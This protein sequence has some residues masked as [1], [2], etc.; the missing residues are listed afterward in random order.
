MCV[1]GTFQTAENLF[2]FT[3]TLFMG[4]ERC[5]GVLGGPGNTETLNFPTIDQ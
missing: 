4:T 2:D 1:N 3:S 5:E